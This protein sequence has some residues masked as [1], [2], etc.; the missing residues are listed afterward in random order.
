MW[1]R[2]NHR[3]VAGTE[4]R[5]VATAPVVSQAWAPWLPASWVGTHTHAPDADVAGQAAVGQLLHA[6]VDQRILPKH[7]ARVQVGRQ[8]AAIA[9]QC[10]GRR[11]AA[12]HGTHRWVQQPGVRRQARQ[13]C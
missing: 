5:Q 12:L 10:G 1:G 7:A 13:R 6:D 11:E 8:E 2:V 3:T 9:L 4:Q